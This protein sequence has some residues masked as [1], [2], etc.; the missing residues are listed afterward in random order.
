MYMYM[1]YVASITITIMFFSCVVAVVIIAI[2][3]GLFY[4]RLHDE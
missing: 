4:G 1:K 2:L 3:F